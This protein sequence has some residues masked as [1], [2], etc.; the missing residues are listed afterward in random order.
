MYMVYVHTKSLAPI[1]RVLAP[2]NQQLNVHFKEP[3]HYFTLYSE[4]IVI[5]AAYFSKIHHFSICK[6]NGITVIYASSK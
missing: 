2:L 3:P 6:F 5:K 1:I 4:I